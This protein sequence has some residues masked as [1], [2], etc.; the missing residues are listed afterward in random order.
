MNLS[1]S[2]DYFSG[3]QFA[4]EV[5]NALRES[6]VDMTESQPFNF[7]LYVGTENDA[8]AC[9]EEVNL[10]GLETKII[11]PDDMEDEEDEDEEDIPD[12]LKDA[13]DDAVDEMFSSDDEE[14][15]FRWLCLASAQMEPSQERF[16]EIGDKMIELARQYE[17]DF[18]GWEVNPDSIEQALEEM[19]GSIIDQLGD[20]E[21]F[22]DDGPADDTQ[23]FLALDFDELD[24]DDD[25][26]P[27]TKQFLREACAEFNVKQNQLREEWRFGECEQW[28]FEQDT[29]VFQLDF[30]DGSKLLADG[31]IVGS[32]DSS[33]ETWEWA[34]NN[35]NVDEAVARDSQRV[36]ELGAD[37]DLD[38]LR[39][40]I[41][42]APG[43]PFPAFLAAI[44]VKATNS[45]GV[46]PGN[47]GDVIVFIMLKDPKWVN[48]GE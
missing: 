8:K 1:E 32:Y 18:D 7:Y 3:E 27:E 44:G 33:E 42:P 13:I 41:I 4:D 11:S 2:P 45:I 12:N 28:G 38:Y 16:K 36:R 24:T 26:S 34:W 47:T 46:Y 22:E 6:E 14:E 10:I 21:D 5:M 37:F 35:P 15:E 39:T 20:L 30:E 23:G 31:Q 40:G 29:G 48:A 43:G 17:G 19:F 9:A 25:L